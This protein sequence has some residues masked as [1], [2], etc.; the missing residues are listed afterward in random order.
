LFMLNSGA[1]IHMIRSSSSYTQVTSPIWHAI[2]AIAECLIACKLRC[3]YQGCIDPLPPRVVFLVRSLLKSRSGV[4]TSDSVVHY[5]VRNVI[6]TGLLA[7]TWAIAALVTWFLL[8]GVSAYRVFDI[9]SGSVYTQ[10]SSSRAVQLC[11]LKENV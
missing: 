3:F 4:R 2:Q 11:R 6:Q 1:S 7:T 8:P 9:T 5:I 10:V